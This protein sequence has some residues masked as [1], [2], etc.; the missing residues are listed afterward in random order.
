MKI[1]KAAIEKRIKELE[2]NV[3]QANLTA[4]NATRMRISMQ[5]G[6]VE[7]KLLLEKLEGEVDKK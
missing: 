3:A 1:E 2:A 4:E 6:I 7:L 5:G